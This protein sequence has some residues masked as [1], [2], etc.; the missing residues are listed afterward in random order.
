MAGKM[1]D[2]DREKVS[3]CDLSV[4]DWPEMSS[5]FDR[6]LSNCGRKRAQ[7]LV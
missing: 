7:Y 3:D 5:D 4:S 6:N 1:S 2:Y